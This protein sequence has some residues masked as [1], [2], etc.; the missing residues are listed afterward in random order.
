[1]ELRMRHELLIASLLL[2]ALMVIAVLAGCTQAP[3]GCFVARSP[4]MRTTDETGAVI[5]NLPARTTEIC[6][7]SIEVAKP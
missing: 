7:G 3:I 1:M 4:S 5:V 6:P 2:V